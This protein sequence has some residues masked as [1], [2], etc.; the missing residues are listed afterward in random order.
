MFLSVTFFFS[1]VGAI[2]LMVLFR[3]W[4]IRAGRLYIKEEDVPD[5]FF[6]I[7]EIE[8]ETERLFRIGNRFIFHIITLALSHMI[9]FFRRL[10]DVSG[11]GLQKL[12]ASLPAHLPHNKSGSS[13]FLK[14]ISAH[15]EEV[16]RENGYHE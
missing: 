16:R 2:V 6:H 1:S 12:S 9:I 10:R 5:K 7:D 13:V 11:V 3:V 14:D 15:K 8:N 4:E